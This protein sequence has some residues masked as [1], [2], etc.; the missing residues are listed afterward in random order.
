MRYI[1]TYIELNNTVF[2][3]NTHVLLYAMLIQH[4]YGQAGVAQSTK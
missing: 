4:V 3:I 1:I 2:L